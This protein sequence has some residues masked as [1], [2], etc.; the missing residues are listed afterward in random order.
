MW[1]G[2]WAAAF[3]DSDFVI[4]FIDP[5]SA[6]TWH[7]GITHSVIMLPFWALLLSVIF[8][9]I[10]RRRYSW[11]AFMGVSML[12][13]GIHITGDV[14]TAFGTMIFA[15]ISMMRVQIPTTFIID[16][17][18]TA[19]I[20]AGLIASMIWK[21]PRLPAA[22]GL[23]LLAGY[24][25]IQWTLQRQAVAVANEFIAARH[26]ESAKAHALPQPLSPFNWMVV[27]E[28]AAGYHRAYVNLLRS[29]VLP[30]PPAD[31]SWFQR[32]KASY[33][34]L[35]DPDWRFVPRYG[36]DEM[37]VK[38]ARMAWASEGLARYRRFALFPAL[39]RV[40]YEP[41]R[42]CVWFYDLRFAI[43]GRR[44]PF[45]YG[46]CRDAAEEPWQAYRLNSGDNGADLFERI[47]G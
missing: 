32:L 35:A 20:I 10:V 34:P 39:Y 23:A 45:R 6:I 31:A 22:I 9:L 17:Y 44:M 7:R 41:A 14:M 13:I 4:G 15:P 24:V 42:T 30:R 47:P 27:V 29:E 37:D 11:R 1:V 36:A 25:G 16:P 33:R 18:F 5:L 38:V 21:I 43:D 2:F 40:D 26:L 8:M 19:I 46:A 3:P 12:A 28:Q